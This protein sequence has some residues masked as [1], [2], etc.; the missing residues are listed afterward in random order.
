MTLQSLVPQAK[1]VTVP[2]KQLD[3]SPVAVAKTEQMAGERI[4]LKPL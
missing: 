4:Q 3:N 1:T 2:V